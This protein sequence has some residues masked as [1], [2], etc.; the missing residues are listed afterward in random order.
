[1]HNPANTFCLITATYG[2]DLA[3]FSL[4]RNSI[5]NSKLKNIHH[6]FVVHTED[7]SAFEQYQTNAAQC[8]SSEELLPNFVEKKRIYAANLATKWGPRVTTALGSVARR[9]SFPQWPHYTGWHTQ[10][11]SKLALAASCETEYAVII[12]S[13]VL[14]T[15]N[16]D[17]SVLDQ[18]DNLLCFSDRVQSS[19]VKGKVAN[20]NITANHLFHTDQNDAIAE[21]YFDTPFIMHVPTLNAM[22]EWLQT[23]YDMPWWQAMLQQPP[24]RWSEFQCYRTYL[25]N[26]YQGERNVIYQQPTN[27]RYVFDTDNTDFVMKNV[28]QWIGDPS[29][30]FITLHSHSAG[31][32]KAKPAYIS[33]IKE[34]LQIDN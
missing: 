12:D 32:K 26:Y 27:H 3:H 5:E 6:K 4:L 1:M 20:W 16:A 24:R 7:K 25:K 31:R 11:I 19:Q 34:R 10:Q 30:H 29:V 14:V 21:R 33:A 18:I 23:T 22:F 15:P 28:N 17:F 8:I 9:F 2:A 13:D